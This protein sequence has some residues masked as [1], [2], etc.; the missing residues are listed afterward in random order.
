MKLILS[1]AAGS[2]FGLASTL[3]HNAYQPWGL[4]LSVVAT[5]LAIWMIGR[6]WGLKRYKFIASSAWF[7]VLFKASTLGVGGELLIEGNT[8]GTLLLVCGSIL[9][10]VVSAIAIPE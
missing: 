10:I 1:L 7:A 6:R 8:M 5:A 9:L 4:I 3:L 2:I